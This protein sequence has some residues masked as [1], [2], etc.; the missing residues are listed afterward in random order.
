M[1]DQLFWGAIIIH[2][3]YFGPFVSKRDGVGVE[4]RSPPVCGEAYLHIK[5]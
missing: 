5:F 2:R 4:L 3:P 1:V